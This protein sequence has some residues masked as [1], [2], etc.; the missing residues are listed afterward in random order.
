[1][2]Q[3]AT[4]SEGAVVRFTIRDMLWLTLVVG[5]TIGWWL[6]GRYWISS[7]RLLIEKN[8]QLLQAA[9]KANDQARL[10]NQRADKAWAESHHPTFRNSNPVDALLRRRLQEIA[11]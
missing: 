8:Q 7:N 2:K 5:L 9:Q 10:A 3:T 4:F 1:M 11:P 6:S